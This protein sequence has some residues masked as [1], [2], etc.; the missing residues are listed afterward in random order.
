MGSSC[1]GHP[2]RARR[3]KKTPEVLPDNPSIR[4]GIQLLYLGSGTREMTG[5]HSEATYFVGDSR[6]RFLVHKQDVDDLLRDREIILA[7]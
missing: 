5:A 3:Q 4:H 6:R 7:P 2:S 1:C